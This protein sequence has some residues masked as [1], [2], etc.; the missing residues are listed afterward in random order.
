MGR[1]LLGIACTVFVWIVVGQEA[2]AQW[3][4]GSQ[5]YALNVDKYDTRY[6]EAKPIRWSD[7]MP[8]PTPPRWTQCPPFRWLKGLAHP[9]PFHLRAPWDRPR[10]CHCHHDSSSRPLFLYRP[11]W[12]SAP[13]TRR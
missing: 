7:Q 5:S 12:N 4:L 13:E 3:Y 9:D 8:S 6:G 1:C 10:R 11:R 2:R